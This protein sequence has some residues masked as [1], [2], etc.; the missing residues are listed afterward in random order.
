MDRKHFNTIAKIINDMEKVHNQEHGFIDIRAD[1]ADE[2]ANALV[3]TNP[4][5]DRERFIQACLVEK[6]KDSHAWF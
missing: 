6:P 5:F 1:V 3:K 2:F 4:R